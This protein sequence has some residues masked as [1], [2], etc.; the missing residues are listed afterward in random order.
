MPEKNVTFV[1]FQ[2]VLCHKRRKAR[3]AADLSL[4]GG[5]RDRINDHRRVV[6]VLWL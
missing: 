6:K 5:I 3:I 2:T 4:L 1:T